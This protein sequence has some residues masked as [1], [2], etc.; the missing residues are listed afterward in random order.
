MKIRELYTKLGFDVDEKKVKSYDASIE[1]TKDKLEKLSKSSAK[2]GVGLSL[3]FTL[4]AVALGSMAVKLSSDSEEIRSKFNIIFKDIRDDSDKTAKALAKNYG[5]S[6]TQSKE[7]LG[8]TADL[9]T[10]FGFTQDSALNLAKQV[11]ELSVDLASF[12]NFSGGAAG[13]SAALTKALLGERESVKSLGISILEEDV[14]KQV[15]IN[16]TKGI[17]FET[18]RQAKAYATLEIAQRQSINAIGDYERTSDSY[19]NKQRIYRARLKDMGEAFGDILLPV[20]SKLLDKTT[21]LIE[22]FTK[23][24]PTTKKVMIGL[25]ALIS[26]LGAGLLTF[27]LFSMAILQIVPVLSM[28]SKGFGILR[29]AAT[30]ASIAMNASLLPALAIAAASAGVL[31]VFEDIL[32]FFK[33]KD[34]FTSVIVGSFKEVA[35]SISKVFNDMI[36]G[37]MSDITEFIDFIKSSL[38]LKAKVKGIAEFASGDSLANIMEGASLSKFPGASRLSTSNTKSQV[39]NITVKIESPITVSGAGSPSDVGDSIVDKLSTGFQTAL[40]NASASNR[41]VTEY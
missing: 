5:L 30:G 27:G 33:G 39:N 8:N 13:A 20:A 15:S 38:S 37:L 36:S 17:T 34:S 4:P 26:T 18:L 22:I 31:L 14:K 11:N 1:T 40:Y 41:L 7:L 21:K 3:A 16:T 23:L 9:L 29:I 19:A 28:L 6:V 2:L 35:E 32:A 25:V 12:T 24:S 10:G